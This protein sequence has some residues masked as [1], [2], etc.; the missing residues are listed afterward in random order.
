M[1]GALMLPRASALRD[2]MLIFID[3]RD[4]RDPFFTLFFVI[5]ANI[6]FRMR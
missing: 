5:A 1:R 2:D 6:F 3:A 4:A